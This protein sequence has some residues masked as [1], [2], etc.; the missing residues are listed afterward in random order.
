M[1]MASATEEASLSNRVEL[2]PEHRR[3]TCHI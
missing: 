2:W 1:F 3:R